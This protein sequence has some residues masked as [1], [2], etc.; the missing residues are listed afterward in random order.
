MDAIDT[1]QQCEIRSW[2]NCSTWHHFNLVVST[3]I[4]LRI[5]ITR[6]GIDHLSILA[7]ECIHVTIILLQ[8]LIDFS[9]DF[10][11]HFPFDVDSVQSQQHYYH[12]QYG[13]NRQEKV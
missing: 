3:G 9:L 10:F 13:P 6:F 5:P 2:G 12:Q 1:I 4:V 7:F 11:L 8:S